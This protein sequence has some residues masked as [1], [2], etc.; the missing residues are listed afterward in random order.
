MDASGLLPGGSHGGE[1]RNAGSVDAPAFASA[2]SGPPG[3]P[4]RCCSPRCGM[5]KFG[6]L[7]TPVLCS[8]TMRGG[9]YAVPPEPVHEQQ[10]NEEGPWSGEL[11]R[12]IRDGGS[13]VPT[14]PSREQPDNRELELIG[15]LS[16]NSI[17]PRCSQ[18]A[19]AHHCQRS[20]WHLATGWCGFPHWER[21][22]NL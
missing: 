8:R 5:A 16:A 12:P 1:T 10:L 17:A 11:S 9:G 20:W 18:A 22:K 7:R 3:W 15:G 21:R 19:A 6:I 4:F 13:A 14:A 2:D